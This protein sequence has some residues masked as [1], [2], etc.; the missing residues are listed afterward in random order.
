VQQNDGFCFHIH[1]L[2]LCLVIGEFNPLMLR[3]INDQSLLFPDIL[4]L[5][6]LVFVCACVS[7]CV[8][9]VCVC[10]CVCVCAYVCVSSLSFSLQVCN[11]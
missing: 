5:V 4:L 8:C 3:D 2:S 1:S 6:M 10:V 11:Y 7:V 9:G